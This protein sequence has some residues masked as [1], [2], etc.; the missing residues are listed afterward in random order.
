REG[1]GARP[2]TTVLA[3]EDVEVL[4]ARPVPADA[5][6][7]ATGGGTRVAASLRVR[8]RDAV[9]LAAAQAFARDVR[10][11][12]RAPG[13]RIAGRTGFSVGERLR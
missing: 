8:V 4:A 9:Y 3:L 11:L 6:D 12:V 5:A 2:G 13:D 7:A 1:D 10:L